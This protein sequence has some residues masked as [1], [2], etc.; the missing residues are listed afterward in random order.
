MKR[1]IHGDGCHLSGFFL[2]INIYACKRTAV[3]NGLIIKHR[4]DEK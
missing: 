4:D 3:E 1:M 2:E